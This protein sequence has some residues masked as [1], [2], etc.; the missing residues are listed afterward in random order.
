MVGV[1][2]RDTVALGARRKSAGDRHRAFDAHVGHVGILAGRCNFSEDEERPVGLDLHRHRRFADIA[3]AQF[4]GDLCS[5]PRRSSSAR[6]HRADQRHGDRAA[7]IDRIRIGETFLAVDHDAQLVAG[8]EPIGRIM[9]RRHWRGRIGNRHR[10]VSAP[11]CRGK[12][13]AKRADR[14]AGIRDI[15]SRRRFKSRV[16]GLAVGQRIQIALRLQSR[17][18]R[19]RAHAARQSERCEQTECNGV[20]ASHLIALRKDLLRLRAFMVNKA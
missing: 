15:G 3:I 7:G 16:G 17:N 5:Q 12:A 1:S 18:R 13:A 19:G 9:G 10:R 20:H 14:A 2:Q 11:R 8:I 6:R 4:G